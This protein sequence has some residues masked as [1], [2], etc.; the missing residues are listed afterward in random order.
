[1]KLK[2]KDITVFAIVASMMFASKKMME[3]LPNVHLLGMFIVALTV[4]Y[5]FRALIPIYIYI[6]LDGMFGGFATWWWPYLYIWAV[7]WALAMLV[8]TRL[9]LK[10]RTVLYVAVCA[11]HGFAFGLLYTPGQMVIYGYTLEMGIAYWKAGLPFD[12]IH[13][14]SNICTGFLIYPMIRILNKVK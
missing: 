5:R 4:V 3:L 13:G 1:M 7:L 8:P 12:M 10:V 2:T 6:M 9:S 14:I 11:L